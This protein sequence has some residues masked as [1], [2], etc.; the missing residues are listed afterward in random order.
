MEKCKFAQ[1]FLCM[2]SHND[3]LDEMCVVGGNRM[4]QTITQ[5]WTV[6][7]GVWLHSLLSWVFHIPGSTSIVFTRS[8]T[9]MHNCVFVFFLLLQIMFALMTG[10][11]QW[12]KSA[13]AQLP[14]GDSGASP[15][16]TRVPSL[17]HKNMHCA[18][19]ALTGTS[20]NHTHAHTQ[21]P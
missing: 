20:H 19:C 14:G 9:Q 12:E 21:P 15:S 16:N 11:L 18:S 17:Q 6:N 4:G 5:Q 1:Q 7:K 8:S 2:C 3:T 13:G 10:T